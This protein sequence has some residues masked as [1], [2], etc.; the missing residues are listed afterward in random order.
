[1]TG[2]GVVRQQA[3]HG[4]LERGEGRPGERVLDGGVVHTDP[5]L[6][7]VQDDSKTLSFHQFQVRLRVKHKLQISTVWKKTSLELILASVLTGSGLLGALGRL[8]LLFGNWR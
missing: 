5:L 1:M 6:E 8:K 2:A 4:V 7:P 3:R